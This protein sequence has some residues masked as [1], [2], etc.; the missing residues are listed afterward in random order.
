MLGKGDLKKKAHKEKRKGIG[1][2]H[3]LRGKKKDVNR[4]QETRPE[5]L[6]QRGGTRDHT[7]LWRGGE[8]W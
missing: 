1:R 5:W 8:Y 4:D 3:S 7:K 6:K 2:T